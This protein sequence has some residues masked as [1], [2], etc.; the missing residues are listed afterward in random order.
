MVIVI[1]MILLLLLL[2]MIITILVTMYAYTYIH[3]LCV[4]DLRKRMLIHRSHPAATRMHT[5]L[6][7]F[8]PE[9]PLRPR[10]RGSPGGGSGHWR[11]ISTGGASFAPLGPRGT[12]GR[13][14][15]HAPTRLP[16]A[17]RL[18]RRLLRL[19]GDVIKHNCIT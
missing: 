12:R 2:L 5:Q 1:I 8:S 7:A 13:P 10:P 19:R 14:R 11:G 9:G 16:T 17:P 4:C 15:S 6:S 3:T 18:V